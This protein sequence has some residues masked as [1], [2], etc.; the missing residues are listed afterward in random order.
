M[1]CDKAFHGGKRGFIPSR[2]F[3]PTLLVHPWEK[4]GKI[5]KVISVVSIISQGGV[6]LGRWRGKPIIS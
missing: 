3:G 2:Q 4:P 1:V 6:C 5:P